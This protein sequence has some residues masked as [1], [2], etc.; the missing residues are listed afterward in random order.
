MALALGAVTYTSFKLADNAI[1]EVMLHQSDQVV[2]GISTQMSLWVDGIQKDLTQISHHPIFQELTS[3]ETANPELALRA[4]AILKDS[5]Q[6]YGEYTGMGLFDK[7]GIASAYSA[8]GSN[9]TLTIS[10]RAY[11]KKAIRGDVAISD[12]LISKTTGKP[13]IVIAI[14][15]RLHGDVKG[16]F[17]GALNLTA[18]ST[19]F[20]DPVKMG[21]TG[22]AFMMSRAGYLCA[23][24]DKS[25]IMKARVTDNPNGR[26]MERSKNG[27]L[28][29]E[30]QG[31]SQIITY[32]TEPKTGWIV[33][34]AAN[35][36]DIFSEVT[37]IKNSNIL[38]SLI[39]L[40][41]VALVVFLI[42][43]KIIMSLNK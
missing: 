36:D 16:V 3:Q 22:Y 13:I 18:F 24:P 11:F 40:I 39:G 12:A 25:I 31:V 17:V 19:K 37:A 42:V 14:P 23:H 4:T 30:W 20:V 5:L 38:I 32:R 15:Y 21:K 34:V 1:S 2:K 6:I 7:K 35:V 10:D 43:R 8:A 41:L 26:E 9:A 33:A 28:R 27:V 29:T